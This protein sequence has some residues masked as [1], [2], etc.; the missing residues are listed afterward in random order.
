MGTRSD[1]IVERRDG[2]WKRV[3]CHWDGHVASNGRTLFEH[4]NSQKL[5]EAVVRLGDMSF[6]ASKCSKPAGHSFDTPVEGY[7]VYY[8]RDR[9]E[10]GVRG[11]LFNSL[12]DA[13]PDEGTGTGF[14][15]VWMISKSW[16]VGDADKGIYA[17]TPLSDALA[18]INVPKPN[19]K[20]FG[21]NFV[22]DTR[23]KT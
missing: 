1:I 18:G 10:K 3:Y 5:A 4:Y 20:A 8:G 14:T 17:L 7:T 6:L 11:H 21:G 19:I 2:K 9:G 16:F 13:W 15:Y 22:I 23:R 12:E